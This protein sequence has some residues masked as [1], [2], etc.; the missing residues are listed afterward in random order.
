MATS[1][2]TN[3]T[4]NRNDIVFTALRKVGVGAEG[5]TPSNQAVRDA[6]NDLERIVKGLQADDLHLYKYDE[7]VLFLEK[8]KQSYN[9]GRSGDRVVVKDNLTT[10]SLSAAAVA[11]DTT[12]TVASASG[13]LDGDNIGVL[14]SDQT[15]HWTTV[16]GSPAGTTITL[17]DAMD[18]AAASAAAVYV[19][20]N[21]APRPLSV[22]SARVQI[23]A[24][25]ETP[26][27]VG[28]REDYFMLSNK[29]ATGVTTQIYYNPRLGNGKLYVWPTIADEGKYINLTVQA[30]I[31]DFDTGVNEPDLPVETFQMLVWMLAEDLAPE[32]GVDDS[33]FAMIK[34]QASKWYN[35]ALAFDD[36]KADITF[37][38]DRSGYY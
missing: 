34:D 3:Y 30:P 38:L 19:F 17:T 25:N 1:G 8:N 20:T 29:A 4:N 10:T 11:T 5:E 13:I 36:E 24:T 6:S 12:I 23:S 21:K 22:T 15:I 32:Y 27:H 28:G 18:A 2:S 33:T 14:C 26:L 31:E 9:L 37:D 7:Y 16:N 35:K